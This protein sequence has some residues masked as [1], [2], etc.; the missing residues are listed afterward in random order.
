METH[1]GC[2]ASATQ[3]VGD[4][5]GSPKPTLLT[6]WKLPNCNRVRYFYKERLSCHRITRRMTVK[7]E[8]CVCARSITESFSTLCNPLDCSLPSFSVKQIEDHPFSKRIILRKVAWN[9]KT[10]LQL[11]IAFCRRCCLAF[12]F[13]RIASYCLSPLEVSVSP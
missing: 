7:M 4:S 3:L 8:E 5:A 12:G 11:G 9:V 10:V 1:V 13:S 2:L 6:I